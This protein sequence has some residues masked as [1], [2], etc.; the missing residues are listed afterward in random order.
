MCTMKIINQSHWQDC[1]ENKLS[2]V[3]LFVCSRQMLRIIIRYYYPNNRQGHVYTDK[4]SIENPLFMQYLSCGSIDSFIV[5]WHLLGILNFV[6]LKFQKDP[7]AQPQLYPP[8]EI[9]ISWVAL[10]IGPEKKK[11][12]GCCLQEGPGKHSRSSGSSGFLLMSVN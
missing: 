7:A 8:F 4:K 11:G 3:R 5:I 6:L 12:E 1:L 2:F 10:G 9:Q